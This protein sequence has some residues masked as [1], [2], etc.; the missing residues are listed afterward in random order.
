M[1]SRT[2]KSG[3]P[4]VVV[5]FIG[6]KCDLDNLRKVNADD[7]RAY[8]D[9]H[10]LFFMETS[11]KTATNVSELFMKIAQQLPKVQKQ[12]DARGPTPTLKDPN[13]GKSTTKQPGTGGC[14]G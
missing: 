10:G 12:K 9:D 2:S 1:G 6:N 14:C 4:N 8:C 7:A 5:T 13:V 3:C 11:A